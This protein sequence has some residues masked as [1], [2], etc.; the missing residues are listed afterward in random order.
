[1]AASRSRLFVLKPAKAPP[2]GSGV[3][4]ILP[5]GRRVNI[6]VA[7]PVQIAVD[8]LARRACPTQFGAKLGRQD[9]GVPGPAPKTRHENLLVF[10]PTLEGSDQS[11]DQGTAEQRMI[12]RVD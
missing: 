2:V 12:H 5:D 8:N 11:P 4:K 1:M 6:Y 10:F 7:D 9:D 3:V